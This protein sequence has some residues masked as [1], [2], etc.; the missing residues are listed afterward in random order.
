MTGDCSSDILD[1]TIMRARW[2]Y[3]QCPRPWARQPQARGR[4]AWAGPPRPA[5]IWWPAPQPGGGCQASAGDGR[6]AEF[7]AK[8]VRRQRPSES[9]GVVPWTRSKDGRGAGQKSDTG[10]LAIRLLAL[11]CLSRVFRLLRPWD[12]FLVPFIR[13][14]SRL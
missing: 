9:S 10:G 7:I 1:A 3:S 14:T 4:A 2:N 5:G 8:Q 11:I 12:L 6:R 13:G